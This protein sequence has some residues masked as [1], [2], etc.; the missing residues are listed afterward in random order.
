MNLDF[1]GAATFKNPL[2]ISTEGMSHAHWPDRIEDN[3]ALVK[4]VNLGLMKREAA[5]KM[6]MESAIRKH[7]IFIK[8]PLDM[9]MHDVINQLVE[10]LHIRR[11]NIVN[12]NYRLCRVETE[13]VIAEVITPTKCTDGLRCDECFGFTYAEGKRLKNSYWP[14]YDK[15]TSVVPYIEKIEK[16]KTKEMCHISSREIRE[17]IDRLNSTAKPADPTIKDVIFNDPAT[18]V[19]WSDG[20]KTVVKAEGESFDPEKGLAMAISKKNLGNKY[21]Y[22]NTFKRWLKKYYKDRPEQKVEWMVAA[23]PVQAAYQALINVMSTKGTKLNTKT[24]LEEAI[25]EAIGFLGESLDD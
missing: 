9:Y 15:L 5:R 17:V 23:T 7:C 24:A 18:I 19:M 14:G 3:E 12:V 13:H 25:E 8:M 2:M 6:A 16:E 11:I 22:Y 1:K 20:T 4:L 21:D 10:A